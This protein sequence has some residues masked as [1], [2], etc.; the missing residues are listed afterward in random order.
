MLS[1]I[2]ECSL[3]FVLEKIMY[4]PK[5]NINNK[6][7][8]VTGL[9]KRIKKNLSMANLFNSKMLAKSKLILFKRSI[10]FFT[11]IMVF[12]SKYEVKITERIIVIIA[13]G[14]TIVP[15]TPYSLENNI[16]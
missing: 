6:K 11:C 13:I 4:P 16:L 3:T 10:S 5:I 12:T 14:K 15:I 8:E 9:L 2:F 7:K 1:F